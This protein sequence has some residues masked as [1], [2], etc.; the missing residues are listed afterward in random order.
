MEALFL[1]SRL[2]ILNGKF[3]FNKLP[4]RRVRM[5]GL[6]SPSSKLWNA[7]MQVSNSVWESL[8]THRDKHSS[9]GQGMC[10]CVF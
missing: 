4:V 7:L 2:N 1:E 10:I 3:H 8:A 5:F 6:E 9:L